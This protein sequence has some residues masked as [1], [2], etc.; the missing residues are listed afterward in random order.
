MGDG[1]WVL[2]LEQKDP[3]LNFIIDCSTFGKLIP[4]RLRFF[5]YGNGDKTVII[6]AKLANVH[7]STLLLWM[8]INRLWLIR[9]P[10]WS[11]SSPTVRSQHMGRR[12]GIGSTWGMQWNP[13][14]EMGR[15]WRRE[16]KKVPPKGTLASARLEVGYCR[17]CTGRSSFSKFSR[18][19]F[20]ASNH[21]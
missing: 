8:A 7:R 13:G 17:S 10:L 11:R 18:A 6:R 1:Q 3:R 12:E 21:K 16:E 5:V 15:K 20:L 2:Y 9:E 14:E 19:E 4:Q